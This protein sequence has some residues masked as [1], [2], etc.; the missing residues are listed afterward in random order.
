MYKKSQIVVKTVSD[1]DLPIV[2]DCPAFLGQ[3]SR[4]KP[5]NQNYNNC[6]GPAP[7]HIFS[8]LWQ[9]PEMILQQAYTNSISQWYGQQ[10]QPNDF[11]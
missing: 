10:W 11:A 8:D 9:G 3:K 7:V 5:G 6:N 1:C 2:F 4:E